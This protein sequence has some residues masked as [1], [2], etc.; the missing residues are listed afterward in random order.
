MFKS[1]VDAGLDPLKVYLLIP[2]KPILQIDPGVKKEKETV[3]EFQ[4]SFEQWLRYCDAYQEKYGSYT[5]D[6]VEVIDM[7]VQDR[8]MDDLDTSLCFPTCL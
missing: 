6:D 4:K 8:L 7:L 2:I 3:Y 5:L 1:W